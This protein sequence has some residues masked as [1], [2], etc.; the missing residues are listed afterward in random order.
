MFTLFQRC[1]ICHRSGSILCS[2]CQRHLNH[3][4]QDHID[5]DWW[6]LTWL[7]VGRHY[8]HIVKHLVHRLKYGKGKQIA[9]ILWTKLATLIHTTNLI[10]QIELHQWR[11]VVTAVPTHWIKQY[12]TRWYNQAELLAQSIAASLD[13]PY[14]RLLHKSRRTTSQIKVSRA[15]RLTNVLNSFTYQHSKSHTPSVIILVDDIVTTGTTLRECAR[16]LHE[17]YPSSQ[18]WGV[19]IARN[20]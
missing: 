4:E 11:I 10:D 18:I 20:K 5:E 1:T 3:Y 8:D 17:Q 2:Q 14:R 7:I 13:L 19:C 12:F 16:I 15:N 6:N 9:Q